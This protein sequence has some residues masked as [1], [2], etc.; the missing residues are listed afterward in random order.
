[1]ADTKPRVLVAED[2]VALSRVIQFNLQHCN[3]ATQVATNGLAALKMAQEKTFALIVTDQQMPGMTGL[4]LCRRLRE[5]PQY[6][7]TPI[8]LVTAKKLELNSEH[9]RAELQI[10]AVLSK[11]F[12]PARLAQDVKKM[13]DETASHLPTTASYES[14]REPNRFEK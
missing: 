6:V 7:S 5:L 1:M 9:L 13:L 14:L 10:N 4:D 8:L 3:I 12:S 2:N 11:P